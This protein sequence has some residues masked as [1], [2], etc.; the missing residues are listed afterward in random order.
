[1][2][3]DYNSQ[4]NPL[5]LFRGDSNVLPPEQRWRNL[6]LSPW[7]ALRRA[8]TRTRLVIFVAIGLLWLPIAIL[9]AIHSASLLK[10]FLFDFAAQ[11]RLSLV[12]S[13]LIG[14]E[15]PLVRRMLAV[16]RQFQVVGLVAEQDSPRFVQLCADL[17]RRQSLLVVHVTM[18][19]AAFGLALPLA[20]YASH[21]MLPSWCVGGEIGGRFTAAG[22]WYLLI[23][24]PILLYWLFRWLWH[25][26]VW[27][28][29]LIAVCRTRLRL[30][31]AH[32]DL[33]GGLRF[34]EISVPGFYPLAF[35]IGAILAGG[36]AN[37]VVHFH[38]PLAAYKLV[39]LF[40][41]V[42]VTL[43]CTGPM[44]LFFPMLYKAK[45]RGIFDYGALAADV[46]SQFEGKWLRGESKVGRSTLDVPDFSSTTDLF[47][48]VA[49]VRQMSFV[50]FGI[51]SV[52]VLAVSTLLPMIPVVLLAVPFDVILPKIAKLLF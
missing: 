6:P 29:F 23:S 4:V 31:P 13:L 22:A 49:N 33:A 1:M 19:M 30:I 18:V 17:E 43:I 48:V 10:E 40:V 47:S 26:M 44:F 32:P 21:G 27:T 9:T 7:G 51:R 24:L 12:I 41:V 25:M 34:L 3:A 5:P 20:L 37:Q 52:I 39:T 50:P 15:E 16:A 35:S 2:S 11:V 46:G 36:I 45:W 28:M 42:V 38:Q 14:M 8:G